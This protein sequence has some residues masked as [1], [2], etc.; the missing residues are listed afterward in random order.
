MYVNSS[1]SNGAK[2]EAASSAHVQ[3][4]LQVARESPAYR[5]PAISTLDPCWRRSSDC[6]SFADARRQNLGPKTSD[7]QRP[8][9]FVSLIHLRTSGPCLFQLLPRHGLIASNLPPAA[10]A[11]EKNNPLFSSITRRSGG[12]PLPLGLFRLSPFGL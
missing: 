5:N 10:F 9:K 7:H 12:W 11:R 1:S 8:D 6:P 3:R 2:S 4:D